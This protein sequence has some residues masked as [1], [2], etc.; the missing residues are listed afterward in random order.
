[1]NEKIKG[2]WIEVYDHSR[3]APIRRFQCSVCKKEILADI[4]KK[5]EY[6]PYCGACMCI[7]KVVCPVCG[8]KDYIKSFKD[9]FGITNSE[10]RF[11]C[12]NCNTYIE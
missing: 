5:Y 1:M 4:A 2:E 10:F 11:K 3:L 12:I 9:D 6:C 7:N 8:R